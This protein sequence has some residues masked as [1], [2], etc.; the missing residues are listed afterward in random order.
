MRR[1]LPHMGHAGLHPLGPT[2]GCPFGLIKSTSSDLTLNNDLQHP[3]MPG[4]APNLLVVPAP[5]AT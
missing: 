4:E 3:A 5:L 1:A 2:L